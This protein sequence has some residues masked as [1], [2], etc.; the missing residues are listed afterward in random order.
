M[1][2]DRQKLG[3][4]SARIVP[5]LDGYC[6]WTIADYY[7]VS[8]Q[9]L[10][11]PFWGVKKSKP[12][13]LRQFNGPTAILVRGLPSF[14][15]LGRNSIAAAVPKRRGVF[16]IAG[17][18]NASGHKADLADKEASDPRVT[19]F[20]NDYKW[21]EACE[22]TDD[23][24]GQVDRIS[25]DSGYV[26]ATQGHSFALKAAKALLDAGVEAVALIP[27]AKGGSSI[28]EWRMGRD[29]FDRATLFGS[30]NYRRL[31]AATNGLTA[32]WWYQ[33][34][35]EAGHSIGQYIHAQTELVKDFRIE[36]GANLPIVY[37]QLAKMGTQQPSAQHEIAEAQRRLETGSGMDVSLPHY[38]MV[39]TFDLPLA[40]TWHLTQAGQKELGRRMALAT[41]QHVY[42]ETVDGTG[43][44]LVN[45]YHPAGE[46]DHVKVVFNQDIN[47][48]ANDYDRQF[49]VWDSSA[50]M[51]VV[52]ARRDPADTRAVLIT[53][54]EKA[55]GLVT[56]SYGRVAPVKLNYWHRSVVKGANDLPAP[57]FG[58]LEVGEDCCPTSDN[59]IHLEWV[60]SHFGSEPIGK[61]RVKWKLETGGKTLASGQTKPMTM[62]AGLCQ[63]VGRTD[64]ELPAVPKPIEAML[65]ATIPGTTVQN[66]WPLWLMQQVGATAA[67]AYEGVCA[68]D[69][70]Y[71][72]LASRRSGVIA[73]TNVAS[74]GA[75]L[76]VTDKIPA[77]LQGLEHGEK[78]LFLGC[79]GGNAIGVSAQMGWW[80]KNQ[81]TGT[82]VAHHDAFRDF[83]G[84]GYASALFSRLLVKA[85]RMSDG[86]Y[87]GV[88]PLIVGDGSQGYL[89]HVFQAKAGRGKLFASS[90]DLLSGTPEADCLLDK[91][92]EYVGSDRFDPTGTLDLAREKARMEAFAN[93]HQSLNGWSHT[94]ETQLTVSYPSFMGPMNMSVVRLSGPQN[95][96]RWHTARLPDD[97]QGKER[98]TFKW[99]AG[100]GYLSQPAGKFKLMLG[101]QPLVGFEVVEKT[102]KWKSPDGAVELED[103][104]RQAGSEDT[105][106][107]LSLTL[108][109]ALLRPGQ[110][111]ELRV[112]PQQNGSLRWVSVY[113][114]D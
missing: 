102:A 64:L 20:G 44:R 67:S 100:M 99:L 68:T 87:D 98:Y 35:S 54:A 82:A 25:D 113:E 18:S 29:P 60:V 34:E 58:P 28:A 95:I 12:E 61:G 14:P 106:G 17:Q 4:E 108:P 2:R 30:C 19:M 84:D 94:I 76:L 47:A 42:G 50:P 22:P 5:W 66:T 114:P 88:E 57:S 96:L 39:V 109:S 46:N 37:A 49:E 6:F 15:I 63:D 80:A 90:L 51:A 69:D 81:Q 13:F 111:A 83:P 23:P 72:E 43:P 11:D 32:L 7:P 55:K 89:L 78:V 3:L 91:F 52:S 45:L 33:G 92:V 101:E 104:V 38:Y 16:I 21:K 79:F 110:E 8:G 73:F 70:V 27:C 107:I 74:E 10:L 103:E 56:V 24:T 26:N 36:M 65:V 62:A 31:V 86:G 71:R 1:Q 93:L 77:A 112:V 40:D 85:I 9:G 105:S 59:H 41:R 97:L 53:L 75:R 48:G